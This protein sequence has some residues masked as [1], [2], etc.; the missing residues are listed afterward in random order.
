VTVGKLIYGIRIDFV[1]AQI[2]VEHDD[3]CIFPSV[4]CHHLLINRGQSI[5]WLR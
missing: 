1:A 5:G 4:E 2:A 3:M